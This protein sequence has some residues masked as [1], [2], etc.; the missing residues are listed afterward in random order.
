MSKEYTYSISRVIRE[1]NNVNQQRNNDTIVTWFKSIESKNISLS[2]KLDIIDFRLFIWKD[3]SINAINF[4]KSTT[5][6]DDEL[7]K[8]L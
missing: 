2:V 8:T 5:S 7:S 6:A 1:K 4:S 3:I